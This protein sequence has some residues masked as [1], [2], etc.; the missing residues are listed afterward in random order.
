MPR[1]SHLPERGAWP[2]A[3]SSGGLTWPRDVDVIDSPKVSQRRETAPGDTLNRWSFSSG[4]Y[5]R[6]AVLFAVAVW[7]ILPAE[8]SAGFLV[9]VTFVDDAAN[10][11]SQFYNDLRTNTQAAGALWASHLGGS[12]TLDVEVRFDTDFLNHHVDR[13]AG[14][15]ATN[16]FV[17]NNG[18][19]NVFEPGAATEIKTGIDPNGA[20]ADVHF[21]F[22]SVYLAS[23]LWF[24]PD[25]FARIAPVPSNRTDAV[26]V[27]LHEFGHALGFNGWRDLI[28]GTLPGDFESTFDELT[29]F[30]G[31]NFFF[32][33]PAAV[34]AYGGSVPL[35]FGNIFHLGNDSPRP[36]SNLIPDLMNGVQFQRGTRYDISPLDLAVLADAGLAVQP[37]AVPEPSSLAL[38]TLAGL[39]YAGLR[40][41]RRR[42]A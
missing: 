36:G 23:E 22:N 20:T 8:C 30:V 24:D 35:T 13:G 41:K 26:S 39:G 34:A 18:T 17:Y 16:P 2:V 14:G 33:G 42:A 7:A 3:V 11:H 28:D 15:S 6:L 27:L 29:S 25:P 32:N 9:N 5:R 10:S 38:L 31:G 4:L 1:D 21:A 40:R 19:Y 12:G 37:A